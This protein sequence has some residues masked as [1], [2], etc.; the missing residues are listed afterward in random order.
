MKEV[1]SFELAS[2]L[3]HHEGGCDDAPTRMSPMATKKLRSVWRACIL[4]SASCAG[5]GPWPGE[6]YGEQGQHC[7]LVGR[8]GMATKV[9]CEPREPQ[10]YLPPANMSN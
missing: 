5:D 2:G 10:Q 9:L 8:P 3:G 1:I 6:G 7:D 4:A